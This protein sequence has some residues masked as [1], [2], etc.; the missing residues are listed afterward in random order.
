[1]S[2][3]ETRIARG[4]REMRVSFVLALPLALGQLATMLMSVVDSILAG[5]YGLATL[6]A[7]TVGSSIWTVAL[8]LCV[9]VLMAIPPSVCATQRRRPPPRDRI[10]VATGSMDR[11]GHGPVAERT[12]LAFAAFARRGS[13]SS[14]RS[15]RRRAG[16]CARSPSAR[17]RLSLYFCFRYLSEGLAWT[18]PTML[19][20]HRRTVAADSARLRADVRP[21]SRSGTGRGRPGLRNRAGPVAAGAGFPGLPAPLHPI[22]RSRIVRPF[23]PAGLAGDP[24]PACARPADGRVDLHGGH[25]VRGHRVADRPARRGR[26]RRAPDRAERGQRLLHAAAGHRDGHYGPGRPRGWR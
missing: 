14:P 6:A 12:G 19:L 2:H 26:C 18:R 1:M 23:R 15:V 3:T 25:L 7:V 8:L 24:R 22:R 5:R 17:R 13:A 16:S 10:A 4:L 21:G 11:A 9:G 20:R